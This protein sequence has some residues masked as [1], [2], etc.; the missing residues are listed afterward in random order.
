MTETALTLGEKQTLLKIARQSLEFVLAGKPPQKLNPDDFSPVLR[1]EGASFV[2][3]T[4]HGHLRG[5]IGAL[6]AYQP[7]VQDVQE[8]AIAAAT[9]DYRFSNVV[10]AELDE[11]RIEISRLTQPI[12]LEY[13]SA[14]DLA[15]KLRP[16]V[17]GVVLRN[18]FQRATFLPQVWASLPT[19]DAFM[20]QLCRKMGADPHIWQ[21]QHLDVLVYQVDE[22]HE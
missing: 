14:A 7:L 19:V 5:C 6:E 9:Q 8:H 4:K 2:T 12:S 16:G 13:D 10:A 21:R 22:F 17:D 3:L 15:A 1:A 18:G 20:A 11:I